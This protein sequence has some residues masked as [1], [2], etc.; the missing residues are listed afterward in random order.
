MS[1]PLPPAPPPPK[2]G[3]KKWRLPLILAGI[4]ITCL[5]VGL[6]SISANGDTTTDPF[7]NQ[8]SAPPPVESTDATFIMPDLVGLTVD[9]A[10]LRLRRH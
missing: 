5:V 2:S 8:S 6:V 9:T 7:A 3:S 4:V 10:T 1:I